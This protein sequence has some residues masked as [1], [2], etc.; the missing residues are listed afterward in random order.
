MSNLTLAVDDQLIKQARIRAIGEGTSVSAKVREFLAQYAKAVPPYADTPSTRPNAQ[1]KQRQVS[2][3]EETPQ[4]GTAASD[5][6][7]MMQD[8][9]DEIALNRPSDAEHNGF[10]THASHTKP[11]RRT[12]R[13]YM[14]EGDYRARARV[15]TNA[16]RILG[17]I[18]GQRD[19][20]A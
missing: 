15:E 20:A 19:D 16:M 1:L 12:L 11:A 17:D 3:N 13:D 7:R 10:A 18:P 4:S 9:R 8:V 2:I 14:Y 5:L 6:L